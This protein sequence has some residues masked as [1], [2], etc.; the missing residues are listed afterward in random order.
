[1]HSIH[2]FTTFHLVNGFLRVYVP[3]N[4]ERSVGICQVACVCVVYLG[5]GVDVSVS[6]LVILYTQIVLYFS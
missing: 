3:F 2:C 1:M 6:V 5:V 4:V